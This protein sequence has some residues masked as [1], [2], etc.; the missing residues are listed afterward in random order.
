MEIVNE[1]VFPFP[2]YKISTLQASKCVTRTLTP[3][4]CQNNIQ[5]MTGSLPSAAIIPRHTV[6]PALPLSSVWPPCLCACPADCR[7]GT[8][9][10]FPV[11]RLSSDITSSPSL[12]SPPIWVRHSW[13]CPN[14]QAHVTSY[15]LAAVW[16]SYAYCCDTPATVSSMVAE[17]VSFPCIWSPAPVHCLKSSISDPQKT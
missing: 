13:S 14:L 1:T 2:V 17:R 4:Q 9:P 12:A 16:Q 8:L 15:G 7:E 11:A 3:K 10:P 5:V 6:H